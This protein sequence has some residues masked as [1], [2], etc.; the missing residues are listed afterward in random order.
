[1]FASANSH[2]AVVNL[3]LTAGANVNANEVN[4]ST[5]DD[6]RRLLGHLRIPLDHGAHVDAFAGDDSNALILAAGKGELEIATLLLDA[7]ASNNVGQNGNRTA[8]I[9]ATISGH[10][11]I[12]ELLLDHGAAIPAAE[13]NE[14][15]ALINAGVTRRF[16]S[17]HE[18]MAPRLR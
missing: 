7:G 11:E 14:W 4:R 1:M 2:L 6:R 13:G 5:V 18:I 10:T 3:L 12:V 8:V 15:M 16:C 17:V 9:K